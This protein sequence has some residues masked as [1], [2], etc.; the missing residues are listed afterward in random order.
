MGL[1]RPLVRTVISSPIPVPMRV[2]HI[3]RDEEGG[4]RFYL[5]PMWHGHYV[6]IEDE[7]SLE[8]MRKRLHDAK[9]EGATITINHPPADKF[10]CERNGGC[11]CEKS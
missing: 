5:G 1:N 10:Y 7:L 3:E 6:V 2:S 11:D 9:V 4:L 8:I